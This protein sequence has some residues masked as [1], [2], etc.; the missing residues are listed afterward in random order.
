MGQK[1]IDEVGNKY[2]FLTVIEKTTDKNG[3][4]A[5]KCKCDCGNE[6]IVRGSDLRTGKITSC[7]RNC[8]LRSLRNGVFKDETG[9]KYGRL[10]VLYRNGKSASNKTKWHCICDCG[11]EVDVLGEELR[12]GSVVSCG[13]YNKERASETQ[14]KDE[15]GNR[16]GKLT[17]ISLVKRSPKAIWLCQCDCGN[18]TEVSGIDLRSGNTKSCGCLVS[19]FE[20]R[21]AT[22]LEKNQI[23]FNRQKTF[24]NLLSNNGYKLK[25]DFAVYN[26]N[27]DLIGLIEYNGQQHYQPINFFGGEENLNRQIENDRK[28]EEYCKNNNIPLLILNKDNYSEKTIIDFVKIY[29]TVWD[30]I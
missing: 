2:G 26:K 12:K 25:F 16:Y 10:T 15:T 19:Y 13:C 27:F 5:W 29:G 7:G 23:I 22:L 30:N 28:K 14:F 8:K 4:T 3:R 1:L 6:K 11:K 17:V 18:T 20:E 24:N 21:I 9:K